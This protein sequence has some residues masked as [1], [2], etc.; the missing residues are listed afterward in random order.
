MLMSPHDGRIDHHVFVIVI[1]CQQ[2]ENAF[3]NTALRPSAEALVHDLPVAQAGREITPWN[4]RSI[5]VKNR[6]D[7]QPVVRCSAADMTFPA[8]QE[9]LDPFPL[10]VSQSKALHRSALLKADHP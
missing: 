10:I 7:K 4:P 8:R 3:E 1:A 9:I 2:L 6:I 5:S